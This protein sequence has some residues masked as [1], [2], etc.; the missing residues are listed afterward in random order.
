MTAGEHH[1]TNKRTSAEFKEYALI[2][3]ALIMYDS[4][5]RKAPYSWYRDVY[6]LS[7]PFGTKRIG[8]LIGMRSISTVTCVHIMSATLWKQA[9]SPMSPGA[10][11]H[12]FLFSEC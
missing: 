4:V 8:K 6:F 11:K 10:K 5:L 9:S 2:E 3:L 1:T 7:S 12:P